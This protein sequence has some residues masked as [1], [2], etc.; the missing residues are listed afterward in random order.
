MSE[1]GDESSRTWLHPLTG[2]PTAAVLLTIFVLLATTSAMRKSLTFDE[3][4]HLTGGASYWV[5]DDYRLNPENGNLSQRLVALPVWMGDY[6]FPSLDQPAWQESEVYQIGHQFLFT[7][8]N[9]VDAMVLHGR[10]LMI[11][12]GVLLGLVVYVVGRRLFGPVGATISLTAYA[13]NP[14]MPAHTRLM[15]SD[16]MATLFFLSPSI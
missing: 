1:R 12:V 6:R 11:L 7:Q 4:P 14:H 2:W 15:T 5:H 3:A 10:L 9:D 16:L 13:F 8:G